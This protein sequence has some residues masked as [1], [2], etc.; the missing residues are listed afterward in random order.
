MSGPLEPAPASTAARLLAVDEEEEGDVCRIC[1]TSGGEGNPLYY[2]CACSGSIKYVHQ[3][4]LLQWLQHSG[5]WKCEVCKHPFAFSPVYAEDAPSQLPLRDFVSGVGARAARSARF[6]ARLALVV[7]V[8][9]IFTPF[10]TCWFARLALTRNVADA[11]AL[12]LARCTPSKF[13]SDCVYGSLLSAAIVFIFL[14]ATSLREYF[15]HGRDN[16]GAEAEDDILLDAPNAGG[17]GEDPGAGARHGGLGGDQQAGAPPNGVQRLG[18]P[19]VDLPG[20]PGMQVVQGNQ[21]FEDGNEGEAEDMPF[22]EIVGMQGPVMH[23]IE[24]GL[25]VLAS[26][27]IFLIVVLLVPFNLG[28]MALLVASQSLQLEGAGL[29]PAIAPAAANLSGPLPMCSLQN[30]FNLVHHAPTDVCLRPSGVEAASGPVSNMTRAASYGRHL[31]G[32]APWSAVP[33]MLVYEQV[34][35]ELPSTLEAGATS[36]LA[37]APTAAGPRG[38]VLGAVKGF[39]FAHDPASDAVTLL[40]GYAVVVL[41]LLGFAACVAL[42]RMLGRDAAPA[43]GLGRVAALVEAAPV[44]VRNFWLGLRYMATVAKVAGLLF[45]ELG[46]FP[47]LCGWWLDVCTLGV[48]SASLLQRVAFL[49]AAPLACSFLHWLVGIV[50]MLQVSIFVSILREVLRPGVLAFLRDPADPNYNPFRDLVD[51]P[52]H[53]H[54]RRVAVS[55]VVY[56]NLVVM[57]VY[58]PVRAALALAPSLFPLNLRFSDPF[59]EIPAD[60]LL[61]HVCVPFTIEH[62]RPRATL[63]ATLHAWLTSIG[64]MLGLADFL[65]PGLEDRNHDVDRGRQL[66]GRG[67]PPP[68]PPPQ[69]SAL[70]APPPPP[71]LEIGRTEADADFGEAPGEDLEDTTFVPRVVALLFMAW[72]T[73]LLLNMGLLVGPI[74]IGRYA[75][76]SVTHLPFTQGTQ[77]ND[78]YAF[79]IGCYMMWGTVAGARYVASYLRTHNARVLLEAIIKWI[80]ILAKLAVLLTLW[81][82]V[83]PLCIGLVFK[84]LIVD[85]LRIPIDESPVFLLYQDWALGLLLLKVWTRLVMLGPPIPLMSEQWR[86][87]FERVRR[88]G[89]AGLRFVWVLREIVAPV[90]IALLTVLCVPFVAAH[91]LFPL[92]GFSLLVNSAVYRFAW[93][94][95]FVVCLA[96]WCLARARTWLTQLHNSIRDDRYLVG[97][98]LHNFRSLSRSRAGGSPGTAAGAGAVSASGGV[99]EGMTSGESGVAEDGGG[100]SQVAADTGGTPGENVGQ[101][102]DVEGEQRLGGSHFDAPSALS[103]TARDSLAPESL[104]LDTAAA[105][106]AMNLPSGAVPGDSC[107]A[108]SDVTSPL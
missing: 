44:V 37:L 41:A 79:G 92:L 40:V 88:D 21:L 47:L 93:L 108:V 90:L 46:I 42:C 30:G 43:R 58:L 24:N 56:G 32:P 68:P 74:A 48:F 14:A 78:M 6:L 69:G 2:P 3:D 49:Q 67:A 34:V 18:V 77:C 63:K 99:G 12:F 10:F 55:F 1:R 4:C 71:G 57:L 33:S 105:L 9:L 19:G 61:F 17:H 11:H 95:S 66:M 87:R 51:D 89:I 15:G 35:L 22:D 76:A 26:N 97:R 86:A 54:V 91:G 52:L 94:G 65:L 80:V 70:A 81:I 82:G 38:E 98:K 83:V 60:M 103:S 31:G 53:K 59:L 50:Y 39:P 62:V 28:R 45:V 72:A 85:P 13:L 84:L 8:W 25:T 107:R 64:R 20:D 101:A 104:Q 102:V 75:F 29:A 73:F 27:C 100:R 36:S 23:L 16:V 106:E 96:L 7:C 5:A